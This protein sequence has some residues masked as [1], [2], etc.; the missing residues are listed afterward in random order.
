MNELAARFRAGDEAA[1]RE[2]HQRYGGAVRTV[3]RSMLTDPELVAEVV[4]QTFI[5]AWRS[6]ADFEGDRDLAPWLYTIAR[7]TAIDVLRR[8]KRVTTVSTD[9]PGAPDPSVSSISFDRVWEIWE[10]RRAVDDLP[11]GERDV[12]RLCN[13]EGLSHEEVA[14]RLGVPVGTVKSRSGRAYR[15]LAAALRH[16]DIF[17][18]QDTTSH[19]EGG[20]AT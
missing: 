4:Q 11:V 17:A 15:R 13:L 9:A 16:L 5:K 2:V 14:E 6:A 12:V 20:T 1:V 7:R 19:V 8:E 3:A 10:V 18:N